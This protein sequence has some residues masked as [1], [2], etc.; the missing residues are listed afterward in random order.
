M[1]KS[2]TADGKR[3]SSMTH[4]RR[5]YTCAGCGR[6]VYGNGG[7]SSHQRSCEDYK[8]VHLASLEKLIHYYDHEAP[9]GEARRISGGRLRNEREELLREL[10]HRQGDG[11]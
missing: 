11:E 5:A 3:R 10:C 6:V 1:S 7:R 2:Y 8:I 4:A 9:R